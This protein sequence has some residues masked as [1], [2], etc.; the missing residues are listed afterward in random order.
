MKTVFFLLT[1]LLLASIGVC[2]QESKEETSQ[3]SALSLWGSSLN[4]FDHHLIIADNVLINDNIS[5]DGF[6]VLDTKTVQDVSVKFPQSVPITDTM[7]VTGKQLD[8]MNQVKTN[9]Y[10]E[11]SSSHKGKAYKI[12]VLGNSIA[13]HGKSEAIGWLSHDGGMAATKEE[14]DYIHLL[15]RKIE[16]LLPNCKIYL[17]ETSLVRFERDFS[18]FDFTTIDKLISYQADIVIFQLGENVNFNEVNTPDLFQ[19]KYVDLINCFKKDKNPLIICTTPFF[20]NLQKNAVIEQV[21]LTTKSYLSDLSH[22]RLLDNQ[23]YAKDEIN[24]AG[25]RSEWKVE[26][27]GLHPG[28][29]GMRNIA[30]QIFIIINASV[31]D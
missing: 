18:T 25:N 6:D 24:Y 26:G 10:Y 9:D 29:Y 21:V 16:V 17:R 15:F 5:K 27:I 11:L 23:N 7:N 1:I 13:R 12:L 2:S 4:N 20:P 31:K 14:N 8:P 22:L 19:K 3:Y 28:D 30:Q